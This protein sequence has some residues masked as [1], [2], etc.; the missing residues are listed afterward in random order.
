MWHG[1]T[2]VDHQV[3]MANDV[4]HRLEELHVGLEVA[5]V[6]VSHRVIVRR[7]DVD[8]LEDGTVLNDGVV[9]TRYVEEVAETLFQEV[10]LQRKR[11][12]R[13]VSIVVLEVWIE[14]HSLEARLPP[15]MAGEH[16]S[17]RR[18]SAPDVSCYCYM[19]GYQNN[20]VT[21]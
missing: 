17:E 4:E 13:D 9:G 11:P 5:V 7:E 20:K 21:K 2:Q 3:R 6:E 1:G 12:T 19:H 15:V 14:L 18:L 16:I 8:T 10:H